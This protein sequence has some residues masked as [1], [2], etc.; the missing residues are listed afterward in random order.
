MRAEF[1][2][3]QT[4][5][6]SGKL[7]V[8]SPGVK[9]SP[10]SAYPFTYVDGTDIIAIG[11]L[12]SVYTD[13]CLTDGTVTR[14]FPWV[15]TSPN[16]NLWDWAPYD[17]PIILGVVDAATFLP[18]TQISAGE[19]ITIWTWLANHGYPDITQ[20]VNGSFPTVAGKNIWGSTQ[21]MFSCN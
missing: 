12:P 15:P 4:G 3:D 20:L 13:V 19:W 5:W 11:N 21:V 8:M 2:I 9:L 1:L 6:S 10:A 14:P 17:D 16:G 7:V 18:L